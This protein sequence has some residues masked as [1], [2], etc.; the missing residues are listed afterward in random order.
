MG[1]FKTTC[2]L[3]LLIIGCPL[4][5]IG[6]ITGLLMITHDDNIYNPDYPYLGTITLIECKYIEYYCNTTYTVKYKANSTSYI[7]TINTLNFGNCSGEINP[8]KLTLE[9]LEKTTVNY[10]IEEKCYE[11]STDYMFLDLNPDNYNKIMNFMFVE[12]NSYFIYSWL[13]PVLAALCALSYILLFILAMYVIMKRERF[14][15]YTELR[16]QEYFPK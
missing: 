3:L 1:K 8:L 2:Q 5:I 9:L 13:G 11:P 10:N 6:F 7:S 4:S 16:D 15:S 14:S 12:D